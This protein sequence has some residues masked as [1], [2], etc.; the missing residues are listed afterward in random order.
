MPVLLIY[1]NYNLFKYRPEIYVHCLMS[2]SIIIYPECGEFPRISTI[3]LFAF[4][5]EQN[6]YPETETP[7]LLYFLILFYSMQ[8][9]TVQKIILLNVRSLPASVR[10]DSLAVIVELYQVCLVKRYTYVYDYYNSLDI[11]NLQIKQGSI[12]Q[13]RA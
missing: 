8:C 11:I 1:R 6:P 4:L 7:K 5:V 12:Q 3:D 13:S 2:K 9:A 10:L